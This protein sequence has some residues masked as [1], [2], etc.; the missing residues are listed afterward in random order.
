[1]LRV[2]RMM[3]VSTE[4]GEKE[5]KQKKRNGRRIHLPPLQL[6]AIKLTVLQVYQ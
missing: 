5:P 3:P 4:E 6:V 2:K 1:M